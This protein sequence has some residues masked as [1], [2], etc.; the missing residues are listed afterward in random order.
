MKI[1]KT[2][3]TSINLLPA[4]GA[5][6]SFNSSFHNFIYGDNYTQRSPKGINSLSMMLDLKFDNLTDIESEDLLSFLQEQF[7]YE[8]QQYDNAGHFTNKRVEPF[9]YLPF[10][11]YKQNKFTCSNYSHNKVFNDCNEVSV[12]MEAIANSTLAS[13]EPSAVNQI[14]SLSGLIGGINQNTEVYSHV[15]DSDGQQINVSLDLKKGSVLYC[16]SAYSTAYLNSDFGGVYNGD[17]ANL[18]AT[19]YNGFP[20]DSD[21][22]ISTNKTSIRNSI[23]IDSPI[24]CDFR[25]EHAY[26]RSFNQMSFLNDQEVLSFDFRPTSVVQVNNNPKHKKSSVDPTYFKLNKYGHNANLNLLDLTF[27]ARSN[28]EAKRILL[29]LESH[30]GYRRFL[31]SFQKNYNN[32]PSYFASGTISSPN[33]EFSLFFCPSWSHTF[34]Y[35]DNHTITAKFVECLGF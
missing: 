31:F 20:T 17:E 28:K 1:K 18:D 12:Q 3:S 22:P 10:Y 4:F 7:E 5:T 26:T 11:P 13:V 34:V 35:H 29:F 24:E 15:Y 27:S 30:L 19:S 21:L 9:D 25:L 8:P 23:Y 6:A 2:N 14:R 32:I 33:E 16:P